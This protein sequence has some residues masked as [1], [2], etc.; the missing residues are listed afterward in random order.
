MVLQPGT[1]PGSSITTGLKKCLH[2]RETK[3]LLMFELSWGLKKLS[4][5]FSLHLQCWLLT[6]HYQREG[7]SIKILSSSRCFH[8]WWK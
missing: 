1:S 2:L 5:Q 6:R 8:G 7:N 4:S 3:S